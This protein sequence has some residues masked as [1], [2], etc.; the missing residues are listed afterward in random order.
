MGCDISLHQEVKIKGQWQ[1]Y[2]HLWIKRD[3]DLF[4]QMGYTARENCVPAERTLKGLPEAI[5][6][7]TRF[8]YEY[9]S[10]DA[11]HP[12]WL[13]AFEIKEIEDWWVKAYP[14][15]YRFDNFQYL[16]GG[17]WGG[18]IEFPNDYKSKR[19]MGLE[20]IRWVFWFD[21]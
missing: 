14:Q 5:T 6:I 15:S 17:S 4:S 1:H 9:M 12:S 16:F 11:H 2:N 13:N 20:D 3:Y 21:N 7:P 18:W 8:H 19:E 10:G